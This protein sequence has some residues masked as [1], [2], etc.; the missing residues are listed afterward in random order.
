L[1]L[2][3]YFFNV[4]IKVFFA[5][6]IKEVQYQTFLGLKRHICLTRLSRSGYHGPFGPLHKVLNDVEILES[7]SLILLALCL[8]KLFSQ[9]NELMLR[10]FVLGLS[11]EIGVGE[12]PVLVDLN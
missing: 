2:I 5:E 8:I 6:L 4:H 12:D 9:T 3:A 11:L 1:G 7:I 10:D